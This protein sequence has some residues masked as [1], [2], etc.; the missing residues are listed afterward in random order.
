MRSFIP[1]SLLFLVADYS[2]AVT[3][4][5]KVLLPTEEQHVAARRSNSRIMRRGTGSMGLQ[6]I[7][8]AQYVTNITLGGV[9]MAVLLDTG[10]SDLWV[11]FPSTAP[12]SKDLGKSLS[13][14]YA[15]G[16]ASGRIRST[17]LKFNQFTIENQAYL[18]V[19]D[20]RS[21]STDIHKQGYS[22]L[23]GLGPNSGSQVLDKVGKKQ[24][25]D[26][27]LTRVFQQ[28]NAKSNYITFLLDRKGTNQSYTGQFTIGEI[29]SDFSAITNMPKLDVEEVHKLLDSDQHW[30]ALTDKNNGIIGPD[31]QVIKVKSI[32]PRAPSGQLVA[33]MDSGFTFS[34][35]PREV[36]DAIYG[37]VKGA[38]YDSTKE[39]WTVP[40]G[41]MLNISFN[42]GG[43]NYPVHPMDTVDDNFNYRDAQGNR[44]CIGAFQPI[45]TAFSLLGN[46]DMIMG[47]NF[48]RNVY[49]LMEFGNWVDNVSDQ[50]DPYIQLLSTT[51][52][53]QARSDFVQFRLS[54]TDSTNDAQYQLLPADQ[55]QH[56]PVSAE[57]KKKK[58]QEM[59]LSRWP[60][61]L[62]GCLVGVILIIGL[63][64]WKCCCKRKGKNNKRSKGKA[65]SAMFGGS[66]PGQLGGGA[67]GGGRPQSYSQLQD[68]PSSAFLPLKEPSP[69][70]AAPYSRNSYSQP[71]HHQPQYQHSQQGPY[72][73]HH[74]NFNPSNSSV[75]LGQEHQH[76]YP[77]PSPSSNGSGGYYGGGSDA[78]YGMKDAGYGTKA[79]QVAVDSPNRYGSPGPPPYS[80]HAGY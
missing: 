80:P 4:P 51:N 53:A 45:T 47:M 22:G 66:L 71:Q 61:I 3:I 33:V 2:F 20:A 69:A 6:N 79:G 62:V 28:T 37:R 46:Y 40:C 55:M 49:T 63:I 23:M 5:F 30:Q 15:I 39:W 74:D 36:S 68:T 26:S 9:D 8:N 12:S 27:V 25:A 17:Q 24:S 54:G 72:Q 78:G 35:V 38:V 13:L 19:D 57:E 32:V 14:A 58:Y 76:G 48:L 44:M 70:A 56:S 52:A 10:S 42:F 21:F 18:Q 73:T 31:G 64:I 59:I 77:P 75:F 7:G 1:L 65:E 34:Q 11:N 43:K 60:Y 29:A 41:Q 67:A 16:S 50:Q